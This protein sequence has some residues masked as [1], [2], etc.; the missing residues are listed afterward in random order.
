MIVEGKIP[1]I[2]PHPSLA[3]LLPQQSKINNQQ[4]SIVNDLST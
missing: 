2:V 3:F 4:S 1:F